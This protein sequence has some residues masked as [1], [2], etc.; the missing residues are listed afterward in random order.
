MQ[1]QC[2]RQKWRIHLSSTYSNTGYLY[3]QSIVIVKV[4]DIEKF[5][6]ISKVLSKIE[7]SKF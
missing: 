6:N 4:L 5:S 3:F 7:V 2:Y 1:K